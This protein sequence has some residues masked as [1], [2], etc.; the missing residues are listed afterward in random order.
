[1]AVVAAASIGG[2]SL[3]AA[4]LPDDA[5]GLVALT[6]F[7]LARAALVAAA[8]IPYFMVSKRVRNTFTAGWGFVPPTHHP[9]VPVEVAAIAPA[10]V[11][12]L[13]WLLTWNR[14]WGMAT[15]FWLATICLVDSTL[16]AR[17]IGMRV[18]STIVATGMYGVFLAGAFSIAA[19]LGVR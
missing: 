4:G 14:F 15:A 16:R 10:A 1:V 17:S 5:E 7:A 18:V 6:A 2:P 3:K 9:L 12:A 19:A 11:T 8:W 13:V